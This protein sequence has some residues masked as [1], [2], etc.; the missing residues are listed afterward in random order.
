[1]NIT[2]LQYAKALFL[3]TEHASDRESREIVARFADRLHH[4]GQARNLPRVIAKFT[5]LWNASRGIVEAEVVSRLPLGHLELEA[6]KRSI[7]KR[8]RAKEIVIV[9]R[10][11]R[12]I[13]GGIVIRVGDELLDG[14]VS[15]QLEKLRKH[16]GSYQAHIQ[17]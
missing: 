17:A 13:G 15:T 10:V 16:L 5:D 1:M 8:Y 14:S 9:T 3:A 7:A 6:V 2:P 11:D 12:S 4:D